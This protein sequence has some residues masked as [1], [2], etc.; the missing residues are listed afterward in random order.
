M[1]KPNWENK[2]R[3]ISFLSVFKT[4]CEVRGGSSQFNVNEVFAEAVAITDQLFDTFPSDPSEASSDFQ[5]G[6]EPKYEPTPLTDDQY[7]PAEGDTCPQCGQGKLVHKSGVSKKNG[8][9]YSFV[10][11]DNFKNGCKYIAK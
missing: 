8:K 7:R 3:R 4:L 2:D 5:K 11:C 1:N 9:A 6:P 10:G